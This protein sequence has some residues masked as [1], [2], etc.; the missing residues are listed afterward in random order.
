[1][2]PQLYAQALAQM[3][4]ERQQQ[5]LQSGEVDDQLPFLEQ[6]MRYAQALR[7]PEERHTTGLGGALGAIGQAWDA[8]NSRQQMDAV[9]KELHALMAQRTAGRSVAADA[10][11]QALGAYQPQR[12]GPTPAQTDDAVTRFRP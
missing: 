3:S 4:P 5:M 6:R 11:R 12:L 10:Y 1:M 7:A 8:H 9:A 2:D